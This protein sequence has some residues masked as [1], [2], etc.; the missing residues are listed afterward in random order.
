[1]LNGAM[2]INSNNLNGS[3]KKKVE[4]PC[5]E[6]LKLP[7]AFFSYF[8]TTIH[9]NFEEFKPC[10]KEK[11]GSSM[12]LSVFEKCLFCHFAML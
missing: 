5:N 3:P 4:S 7:V 9:S 2:Q 6:K 12:F 11:R 8:I 10:S 1:M